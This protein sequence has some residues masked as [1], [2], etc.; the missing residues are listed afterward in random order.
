MK[1]Q[2][3]INEKKWMKSWF[4]YLESM[5]LFLEDSRKLYERESSMSDKN[6]HTK[7]NY[8]YLLIYKI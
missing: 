3:K 6:G 2:F 5:T 8:F 4:Y 7:F 1:I